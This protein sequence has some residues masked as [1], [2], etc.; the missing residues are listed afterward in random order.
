MRGHITGRLFR[1]AGCDSFVPLKEASMPLIRRIQRSPDRFDALTRV[2]NRGMFVVIVVAAFSLLLQHGFHIGVE[3]RSMLRMVDIAVLVLFMAQQ[4]V[5]LLLTPDRRAHLRERRIEY[6]LTLALLLIL[7][8]LPMLLRW[9]TSNDALNLELNITM[10][11]VVL[12]QFVILVDMLFSAVRLS[13]RI[14]M[15]QIQP[16]RLFIASFVF[17][18]LAGTLGLLLP[19]ATTQGI[20]VVDAL[21]TS[22]SAVCVTGLTAV[23]TATR[24]T[25]T[26]QLIIMLLIQ[27][28]GLG[29]MTFTTFFALFAGRLSIRE[30]V[31]MQDFLNRE[32]LGEVRRTLK[33]IVGVTF[34]IEAL[35]ALLLFFSWDP[36][37]FSSV[38]DRLFS[39]IFHSVSAFCNAGF[40]LFS[41]N[42][43]ERGIAMNPMI[44]I[45][46]ASLIVLGGLGFM[47]IMNVLRARP[48]SR[49]VARHQRRLTTH[50]RLVL[51]T[52]A[53]LIF[54][55]A[56]LYLVMDYNTSLRDLSLGE[57]IL[58]ALFQS[59]STRT[60]GFNTVDIGAMATPAT[61]IFI[62]LMFIGASPAS[63][64]GGIKTTTAAVIFLSSLNFIRGKRAIEVRR[65]SITQATVDRAH[66]VLWFA[67]LTVALSIIL[68]SL[69]EPWPLL[70]IVFECTS[71]MG[72]VGLSR[73]ITFG[74]TDASKIVLVLTML[75]GR[76][77]ALTI[78]QS[79]TT[80]APTSRYD[81]PSESVI[82]G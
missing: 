80:P 37:R 60:A 79:L 78:V 71:A 47:T 44:N 39:S 18:I 58:A 77:G 6:G 25:F 5:K 29:L 30:R 27:V 48:W 72:T 31:L 53:L 35:G 49:G 24:F 63:T 61:L 43:A 20:S 9:L 38:G 55:G 36:A 76:V 54:F 21:F 15:K 32:N 11:Y 74:L 56:L 13:R 28:G 81:Y 1:G 16:A 40:S 67:M 82:V 73:G 46:I 64:G 8:F 23:D 10:V 45:T 26:G 62:I 75:I 22:T 14:A 70:D 19:R 42:L 52:T 33:S 66:A 17:V 69:W 3:L 4:A 12:V 57:K 59:V 65:R 34:I 68:L 51:V 41:A 50:T 7:P 2:I